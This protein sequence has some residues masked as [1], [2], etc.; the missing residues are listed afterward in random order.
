[1][2]LA[3]ARVAA[4]VGGTKPSATWRRNIRPSTNVKSD[5]TTLL[6]FG[7]GADVG[8][9]RR[10]DHHSGQD[11]HKA[12]QESQSIG[13]PSLRRQHDDRGQKGR[14]AQACGKSMGEDVGADLGH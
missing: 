14:G 4:S 13:D 12:S 5:L 11:D 7:G 2:S 9:H 3:D 8:Q 10:T 1:M 6:A